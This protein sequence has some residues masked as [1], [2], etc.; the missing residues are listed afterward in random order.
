MQ[1]IISVS[2]CFPDLCKSCKQPTA[3][4]S[5]DDSNGIHQKV[6]LLSVVLRGRG[7][8]TPLDRG[9]LS[10]PCRPHVTFPKGT[11]KCLGQESPWE[12]RENNKRKTKNNF[13]LSG[14]GFSCWCLINLSA[15]HFLLQL[16]FTAITFSS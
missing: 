11:V 10:F 5:P 15:N 13:Y 7:R 2:Y 9:K 1:F 14:F 8:T 4:P 12:K 6:S 16:I 3:W